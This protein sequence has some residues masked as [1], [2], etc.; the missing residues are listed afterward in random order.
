MNDSEINDS[1]VAADFKQLTFSQFSRSRVK[2]ELFKS[3]YNGLVEPA[4]YW[5]AELIC[6]GHFQDVWNILIHYMSK[7]IHIANPKLPIYLSLRFDAFK[8]IV[9]NGYRDNELY[10]RNNNRIR[11]IFGEI[12]SIICSSKKKHAFEN[13]SIKDN[14]DFDITNLT[15]KLKAP[16]IKFV[17]KVFKKDDPK[18]LFIAVNEFL[19]HISDDIR[20]PIYACYWFEWLSKF[21]TICKTKNVKCVCERRTFAPVPDKFQMDVVWLIWE[22]LLIEAKNKSNKTCEKI[23]DS[24]L[25]LY[26]IKYSTNSKKTKKYLIYA[27]INFITEELTL[28]TPLTMNKS[29]IDNI[30][31]KINIIYKQV[32]I[33]EIGT[34]TDYLFTDVKEVNLDKTM[35][36]LETMNL[37]LGSNI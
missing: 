3:L 19:Y 9:I 26:C 16:S 6:S 15:S 17:Y 34:T 10:L 13:Y 1:R 25:N 31:S 4:C 2:N 20:D 8:N 23:I 35:K 36:K 11:K 32:K 24:L 14:D 5:S 28:N 18:E 37:A 29:F 33:N 21:E 27:A 30:T 12:I 7:H 22:A